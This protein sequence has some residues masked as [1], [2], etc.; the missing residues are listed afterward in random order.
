MYQYIKILTVC[1]CVCVTDVGCFGAGLD[2]SARDLHTSNSA[3]ACTGV[4]TFQNSAGQLKRMQ[5]GTAAEVDT[6]GEQEQQLKWM[7]SGSSRHNW[8]TAAEADAIR[9]HA[10]AEADAIG[11]L[12]LKQTQLGSMQQLKRTQSG[13]CS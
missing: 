5:L 11:E 6:I 12:Q 13:S 1:L 10:A 2:C 8:G 4:G 3:N 9:E 7:Q